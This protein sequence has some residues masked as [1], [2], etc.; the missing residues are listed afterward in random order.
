MKGSLFFV[1]NEE[2]DITINDNLKKMSCF[3]MWDPGLKKY[4]YVF[5]LCKLNDVIALTG[6]EIDFLHQEG[7][8][9]NLLKHI[10]SSKTTVEMERYKGEG[11]V[12]IQKFPNIFIVSFPMRKKETKTTVPNETVQITWDVLKEFEIGKP[13]S[14]PKIS[15]EWCKKLKITRFYEEKMK[16]MDEI[17]RYDINKFFRETGSFD[18][19]KFTGTRKW[20]LIFY[21]TLKVLQHYGVI[22]HHKHGTVE[23]LKDNFEIDSL[24]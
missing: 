20:Y 21:G 7:E 11:Y 23:R 16:H 4:V 8:A 14:T 9:L 22:E 3:T 5:P 24:L 12:Y 10:P 13:I 17:S 6:K 19:S 2:F 15:E 1:V 18:N